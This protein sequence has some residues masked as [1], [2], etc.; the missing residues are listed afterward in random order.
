M[1]GREAGTM[2]AVPREDDRRLVFDP[3]W[4]RSSSASMGSKLDESSRRSFVFIQALYKKG[5]ARAVERT[6]KETLFEGFSVF[7][8]AG[9]ASKASTMPFFD[10][11]PGAVGLTMKALHQRVYRYRS[12]GLICTVVADYFEVFHGVIL[13]LLSSIGSSVFARDSS[14]GGI[15][16]LNSHGTCTGNVVRLLDNWC[17]LFDHTD[18]TK[19]GHFHRQLFFRS[20][21][22][23]KQ[24]QNFV[25]VKAHDEIKGNA[26]A[27]KR[28]TK[29]ML[30]TLLGGFYSSGAAGGAIKAAAMPVLQ[31]RPGVVCV[32]MKELHE[33][34]D[35]LPSMGLATENSAKK[36]EDTMGLACAVA[37][38]YLEVTRV[39]NRC[40]TPE[41]KSDYFYGQLGYRSLKA[42]G[43]RSFVIVKTIPETK[44]NA[45]AFKRTTNKC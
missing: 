34:V 8:A 37:D 28:T 35:R 33:W 11:R 18:K 31:E 1:V 30:T 2:C 7:G 26:Y 36:N 32:M 13:R 9:G 4:R 44:G 23:S 40:T 19:Y 39:D 14:A 15:F 25:F 17:L 29:E 43:A 45:Y 27:I 5:N 24:D 20:L 6:T 3:R 38:D 16:S 41:T 10:E 42:N 12:V 21:V 22:A